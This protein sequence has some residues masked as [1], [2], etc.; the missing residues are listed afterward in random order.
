M[1]HLL[2]QAAK[3]AQG[4]RA[5]AIA[6]LLIQLRTAGV[7]QLNRLSTNLRQFPARLRVASNA[8]INSF[9]A[10]GGLPGALRRLPGALRNA[11][12]QFRNLA[13]NAR[14]AARA[15][16]VYAFTSRLAV[17]ASQ[18]LVNGVT[19]MAPLLATFAGKAALAAA[20]LLPL[21]GTIGNLIPLV[22][23]IVP[24]AATAGLAVL[25][26]KLAF[27]GMKEALDAGLSGDVEEFEKALKKLAPQAADTVRALV[28]IRDQWKG[29][30]KGFQGRVFEGAA[31]ELLALSNFIKPIADRWLPRLAL[32]FAEVRNQL[33]N[34][35]ANFAADGRLEGVW[36]NLHV[37]LSDLLDVVSPLGRAFGDILQ[38]AAPR[39]AEVAGHIK[40]AA[41]AFSE[42]IRGA[43]DSG[44]LGE[45]LDKAMT[46]FGKLK[47]IVVN[48]STAMAGIFKAS[49]G[50]GDSM[51]DSFVAWTKDLSDWVNSGD[52]QRLIKIFSDVFSVISNSAPV[53]SLLLDAINFC[54]GAFKMLGIVAAAVWGGLVQLVKNAIT[55]ILEQLGYIVNGAAAA[56]GW[57]PGIGDKLRAAENKFNEWRDNVNNSLNGIQKTVDIT[58]VYRA[59]RIGPHMVSG[60]QQSGTY[61]SGIGGRASGGPVNKGQSVWVGERGPELVSFGQSGMVHNAQASRRMAE[62]GSSGGG[63]SWS[64]SMSGLDAMFFRWLQ[65]A[66]RTGKLKLA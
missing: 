18:G 38:V 53:F 47:D 27:G 5:V 30:A 37:A 35:L 31:S 14:Q 42:W 48:L 46:T 17:A 24:A 2:E 36:R 23:L 26:L 55:L 62:G 3:Q 61:S 32:R 58:V 60:S 44:K 33:A 51:L 12:R 50:G 52:G 10:R 15:L 65:E 25:G 6:P 19:R 54:V 9:N 4:R 45:W 40:D 63:M 22:M 43:R 57:I 64:G 59:V 7:N 1:V 39:F 16:V 56:F 49:S 34:G 66:I 29:T 8:W 41:K 11:A 13:Q 21:A 28:K 20:A